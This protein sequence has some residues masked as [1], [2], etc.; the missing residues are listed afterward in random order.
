[1]GDVWKSSALAIEGR[2]NSCPPL[3]IVTRALN[4]ELAIVSE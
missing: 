1:M 3:A 4:N 2:D